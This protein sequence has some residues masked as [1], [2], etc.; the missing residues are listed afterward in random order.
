M[1]EDSKKLAEGTQ[2]LASR[3]I[4]I[5]IVVSGS[6]IFEMENGA[7]EA[8][9]V[10]V[11]FPFIVVELLA[12]IRGKRF[13]SGISAFAID[14]VRDAWNNIRQGKWGYAIAI[15]LGYGIACLVGF[16][17][18]LIIEHQMPSVANSLVFLKYYAICMVL[19]SGFYIT[20]SLFTVTGIRSLAIHGILWGLV[21]ACLVGYL[22]SMNDPE[23]LVKIGFITQVTAFIF[24]VVGS[25]DILRT[26]RRAG[27]SMAILLTA[28]VGIALL[29]ISYLCLGNTSIPAALNIIGF[30]KVGYLILLI[31]LTSFGYAAVVYGTDNKAKAVITL[32]ILLFVAGYFGVY[33]V[34]NN[35]TPY[36]AYVN[37]SSFV[38][39]EGA[40][41]VG[42][43]VLV[44]LILFTILSYVWT[45]SERSG[46][47]IPLL[48]SI[49]PPALFGVSTLVA[50][51]FTGIT[52]S[53]SAWPLVCKLFG[54]FLGLFI[55]LW[56]TKNRR[57][58][59]ILLLYPL[60][61][62]GTFLLA[63]PVLY[64]AFTGW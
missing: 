3:L 1:A 5:L 29:A 54:V 9:T 55:W 10:S 47:G 14:F 60:I 57:K 56:L 43:T 37:L 44:S 17:F 2:W 8:L 7:K 61:I 45:R 30:S 41:A 24:F 42:V 27:Q 53:D 39:S 32:G 64:R 16:F 50:P 35:L 22:N 6:Y 49:L 19:V 38:H 52:L 4:P 51:R 11:A 21:G 23:Y 13:S 34:V 40:Y 63:M 62:V 28:I 12:L 25:G 58:V 36:A 20:A 48:A 33:L 59:G 31:G 26:E 15:V 46:I 18:S